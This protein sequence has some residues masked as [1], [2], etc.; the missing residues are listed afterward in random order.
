MRM[1]FCP[2][3]RG[4]QGV[5]PQVHPDDGL[6]WTGG[7]WHLA[8]ESHHAIG[9]PDFYEATGQRDRTGQPNPQRAARAVGQDQLPVAD[10]RILVGIDHIVIATQTPGIARLGLPILAQLAAR[11]HRLAELRDDLLRALCRQARIAALGPLLPAR[12]A[13]PTPSETADA[14]VTPHEVIPQ[15]RRFLAAGRECGPFGCI[16]WMPRKF[17]RAIAHGEIIARMFD[18]SKGRRPFAP[19]PQGRGTLAYSW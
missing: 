11:V 10:A 6:L 1:T 15:P 16:A 5:H 4:N 2:V 14:V 13:R 9:E 17:Y 8:D 12:L 7:V 19:M 18:K 3:C